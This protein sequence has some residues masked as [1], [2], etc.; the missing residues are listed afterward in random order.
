MGNLSL[1]VKR[2]NKVVV[3]I[4]VCTGNYNAMPF[5]HFLL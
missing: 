3:A 4:E 5:D 2:A 1:G